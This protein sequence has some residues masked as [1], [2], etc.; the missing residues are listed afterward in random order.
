MFRR[1]RMVDCIQLFALGA[2]LSNALFVGMGNIITVKIAQQNTWIVGIS[3]IFLGIIPVLL[4]CKM[5]NYEPELTLIG[6]IN[7]IFGKIF[8]NVINFILAMIVF[9]ILVIDIW[10]LSIFSITKYL[11]ET[12]LIFVSFLFILPAAYACFKGIETISRTNLILIYI[13]ILCHIVITTSLLEFV[14]IKNIMPILVDGIAPIIKGIFNFLTYA[15]V[16]LVTILMIP[17]AKVKNNK[18]T[19]LAIV[20][21]YIY[22]AIIMSIV[23][24]MNVS[25]VGIEITSMYR[26]PEYFIMKKVSIGHI[27]E[28]VENFF[29]VVWIFNMVICS[30]MCLY[31]VVGYIGEVGKIIDSKKRTIVILIVSI[32]VVYMS[33]KIFPHDTAANNFMKDQFP[34]FIGLPIFGLLLVMNILVLFKKKKKKKNS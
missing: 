23:F 19:T 32:I 18:N 27:F 2:M 24:F 1:N 8:G 28:N 13:G 12:P 5:M 33:G 11:T 25:T 10:G 15:I 31:Y 9:A 21:G 22:G 7:K 16:P 3:S 20:L 34:I 29:S 6:K 14:E 30:M 26:Y 4:I 17:K